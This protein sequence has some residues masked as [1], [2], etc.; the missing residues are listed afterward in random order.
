MKRILLS[1]IIA[2]PLYCYSQK[3]I[4]G[5]MGVKFGT[6]KQDLMAAIKARGGVLD[7]KT[8][9]PNS[10]IYDN[11]YLAKR[12]ARFTIFAIF[13]N[14][15]YGSM[16]YFKSETESK[17]VDLFK[18]IMNDL[19]E[20]Y[21]EGD[22]EKTFKPPFHDG[23]EKYGDMLIKSGDVV[24]KCLWRYKKPDGQTNMI[25]L[26]ID[27]KMNVELSYHDLGIAAGAIKER[28][29]ENTKDY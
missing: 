27:E 2:I 20:I 7:V 3:P 26:E 15:F 22:F 18:N 5:F 11:L 19:N 28:T 8:S 9:S 13:D 4:E 14:K 1:L 10:L 17:T 24:Y 23:D 25:Q 16:C 21:G 12:L 6:S 29:S